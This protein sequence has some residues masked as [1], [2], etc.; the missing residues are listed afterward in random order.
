MK[1]LKLT[2]RRSWEL[3]NYQ[4]LCVALCFVKHSWV[5]PTVSGWLVHRYA[6]FNF[7][8]AVFKN[9]QNNFQVLMLSLPFMSIRTFTSFI[10]VSTMARINVADSMVHESPVVWPGSDL[11]NLSCLIFGFFHRPNWPHCPTHSCCHC[12]FALLQLLFD[13]RKRVSYA[14]MLNLRQTSQEPQLSARWTRYT[15]G[16]WI[17]FFRCAKDEE[18]SGYGQVWR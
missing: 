18:R 13:Y 16:T 5:F 6:L 8:V 3:L 14:E 2:E 15:N 9:L 11:V 12:G 4:M 10:R 1:L 17:K 7:F